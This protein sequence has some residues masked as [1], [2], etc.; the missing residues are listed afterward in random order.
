ML[1]FD[2]LKTNLKEATHNSAAVDLGPHTKGMKPYSH[3]TYHKGFIDKTG[4]LK[5]S[6]K[7]VHDAAIKAGYRHTG[8]R[9]AG[10]GKTVHMYTKTAGP[11]ADHKMDIRTHTGTGRVW[12][13]D[14]DTTKDNS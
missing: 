10:N 4:D 3:G 12:T 1:T 14:H 8:S 5:V 11:Y 7:K 6:H 9:D 13:I 2:Q